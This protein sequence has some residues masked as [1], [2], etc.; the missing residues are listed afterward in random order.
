[1]SYQFIN[2]LFKGRPQEKNSMKRNQTLGAGTP[3]PFIFMHDKNE[4]NT[5]HN[6]C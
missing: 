3:T 2:N 5:S 1:M 4:V 6:F